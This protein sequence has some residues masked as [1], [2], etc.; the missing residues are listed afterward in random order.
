MNNKVVFITGT[1]SGFGWLT[2]KA[3]AAAGHTVYAT[4]RETNGKN[5]AK[6]KEL[7]ELNN[8]T[9]LDVTITDDG[10][11]Q[12][13]IDQVLVNEGRIDVLINNAGYGA[14]GVTESFTVNDVQEMFDVHVFANWRLMKAVLPAMRR[15]QDGLIVN[16]SSGFGRFSFPFMTVYSAAKFGLEGMSEG[17]HYEVKQLGID[18]AIVQ[19]GAYPTDIIHK[20]KTGSD[21]SVVPAYGALAELPNNMGTSLAKMFEENNPNPQDVADAVLN[22]INLPKGQRPLRNVV[23]PSTGH[24]VKAANEA[25]QLQYDKTLVAFGMGELQQEAAAVN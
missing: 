20:V 22:L 7:G 18:V 9:V 15:R 19:P 14:M 2:A 11:V 5:A 17:L 25:V 21:A 4:M 13:A 1:N 3:L 8:I 10:S 16:V 24:F 6:A 12:K 23:D